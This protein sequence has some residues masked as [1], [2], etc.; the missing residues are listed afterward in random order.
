ME[1]RA[2]RTANPQF[3]DGYTDV[4]T[5]LWNFWTGC[6]LSA[7]ENRI[8]MTLL[9]F[10]YGTGKDFAL[11]TKSDIAYLAF[12]DLPHVGRLLNSLVSKRVI[13]VKNTAIRP[14]LEIRINTRCHEWEVKRWVNNSAQTQ[15][16][17]REIL[18][19]NLPL[20]AAAEAVK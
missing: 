20:S 17:V 12:V 8:F 10:S 7:R 4:P 6:C 19:R 18:S 9:R 13:E 1:K 5:E 15:H 11:L 16:L 14:N 3:Q 2:K